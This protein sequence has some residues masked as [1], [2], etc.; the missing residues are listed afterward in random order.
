MLVLALVWAIEAGGGT[1]AVGAVLAAGLLAVAGLTR[2]AARVAERASRRGVIVAV[3]LAAGGLLLALL[4]AAPESLWRAIALSAAAGTGRALVDAASLAIVHHHTDDGRTRGALA[5]LTD[6]HA[7][8]NLLGL[9]AILPLAVGAGGT[10]AG[11]AAAGTSVLAALLALPL[12]PVLDAPSDTRMPLPRVMERGLAQIA[13]RR[14]LRRATAGDLAGFAATG[15]VGALAF[16]ELAASLGVA[17]AALA[18]SGGVVLVLASRPLV[19]R[20]LRAPVAPVMAGGLLLVAVA[21]PALALADRMLEAGAAYAALLIGAALTAAAGRAARARVP[22]E[23]RAPA[24]LVGGALAAAAG[25]AGAVTGGLAG[26]ALGIGA[27]LACVGLAAGGAAT[28]VAARALS[29]SRA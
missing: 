6:R 29:A 2:P 25:A 4:A 27:A 14:V 22:A 10:V 1:S 19:D 11:A 24:G 18:V 21:A 3:H 9:A 5:D 28:L 8:G 26:S 16:P 7:L 15:A 12:H 23:L 13:H 17:H 20:V